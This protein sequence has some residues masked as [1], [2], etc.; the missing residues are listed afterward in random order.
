VASAFAAVL[1]ALL[2]AGFVI[3]SKLPPLSALL[4]VGLAVPLWRDGR[5]VLPLLFLATPLQFPALRHLS[6]SLVDAVIVLYLLFAIVRLLRGAPL[7]DVVRRPRRV[8]AIPALLYLALSLLSG[9]HSIPWCAGAVRQAS[10]AGSLIAWAMATFGG[11]VNPLNLLWRFLASAALL[12]LL[13]AH[14]WEER[15]L[16][17]LGTSALVATAFLGIV[18]V[19]ERILEPALGAAELRGLLGTDFPPGRMP[20]TFSWP[21]Q[22]ASYLNL[23]LPLVWAAVFLGGRHGGEAGGKRRLAWTRRAA[24]WSALLG[25]AAMYLSMTRGG[26]AGLF[27]SLALLGL[28]A[29]RAG[30]SRRRLAFIGVLLALVLVPLSGRLVGT[31]VEMKAAEEP[32]PPRGRM[33]YVWPAAA[34]MIRAHPLS[35][36]GL[37]TWRDVAPA[38][39]PPPAAA[40]V[41]ESATERAHAHNVFVHAAAES[42]IPTALALLALSAACV[43]L[44]FRRAAA[45]GSS[46]AWIWVGP[47]A[48]LP[49]FLAHGLVEHV[50]FAPGLF[51]CFWALAGALGSDPRPRSAE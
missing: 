36:V 11:A 18:A 47:A 20:A 26:W 37:G 44:L 16:A 21:T 4:L 5:S 29:A 30:V 45:R 1:L 19:A 15:S 41:G 32:G 42:G 48:A 40:V 2:L 17:R 23:S 51:F 7:N 33:G 3:R 39:A 14:A 27:L 43:C 13:A 24:P 6:V 12:F 49:G 25:L 35:G 28:L 38:Y 9:L 34:A 31:R 8:I 22:L 46:Q 10:P 50:L